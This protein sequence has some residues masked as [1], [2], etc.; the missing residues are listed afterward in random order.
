MTRS[1]D[2]DRDGSAEELRPDVPHPHHPIGPSV[3]SDVPPDSPK[4]PLPRPQL[5]AGDVSLALRRI[6]AS[7]IDLTAIVVPVLAIAEFSGLASPAGTAGD[8]GLPVWVFVVSF[9]YRWAM[10]SALGF[11]V[12]KWMLGL[13]LVNAT[14]VPPRPLTVFGREALWVLLV[15][16]SQVVPAA[17]ADSFVG[18][19][20]FLGLITDVYSMFRRSDTRALHDLPFHTEVRRAIDGGP[21]ANSRNHPLRFC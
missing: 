10:Q 11:T 6:G 18:T 13:R 4:P 14:G 15:L 8:T 19:V 2:R 1:D 20:I 21:Q 9:V 5:I 17:A 12:G 7:I 3:D 16:T